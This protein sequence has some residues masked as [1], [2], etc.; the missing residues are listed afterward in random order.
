VL[1]AGVPLMASSYEVDEYE[2]DRWVVESHGY[3]A[4]ADPVLNPYVLELGDNT[5]SV[6]WGRALWEIEAAPGAAAYID[7]ARLDALD[8]LTRM[9]MHSMTEVRTPSPPYG[10]PV[11]LRSP[12]AKLDLVHVFDNRFVD[13]AT[14]SALLLGPN[15]E[16]RRIGDIPRDDLSRYPGSLARDIERAVWAASIKSR[17]LL[18]SYPRPLEIVDPQACA[19]DMLATMREKAG[20]FFNP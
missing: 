8:T 7:H 13:M 15:A 9:V 6:R 17:F 4:N 5:S 3:R 11:E 18:E 2:M 20:R 14:G 12:H 1:D 19:R 16:L 10:A